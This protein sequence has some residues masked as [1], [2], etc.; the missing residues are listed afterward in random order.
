MKAILSLLTFITLASVVSCQSTGN[1]SHATGNSQSS[2]KRKVSADEFDKK[3]S[4][5]GGAQL[6]DVRTP[7][8]YET[9]H[10]KNAIN[11]DFNSDGFKEQISK[12]KK[13][14]P[15]LIY[16]LS[17]G[18]SASAADEMETMGFTEIYNLDGGIM[19]WQS[20]GKSLEIGKGA[21]T[22]PGLTI[23]E[24]QKM[25]PANK[26]VL[27]DYNAKWC[28]PCKKMLPVLEAL[29]AKQGD[30]LALIK[31]DADENKELLNQKGISGIPYL[32]LYRDGKLVWKHN[33]YIDE[34]QLLKET[35]L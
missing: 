34:D 7:G 16:C 2:I 28:E 13:S 30:K 6:I 1:N 9:G 15:I 23:D 19:K 5:I 14:S 25:I 33:G 35:N 12:M 18:R 10:L 27:V 11:I 29:S 21:I 31:I 3:L 17:G 26:T 32:E 22:V 24:F 4:T 20:E 8:E